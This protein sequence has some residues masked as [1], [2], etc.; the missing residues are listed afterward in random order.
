MHQ[1]IRV[2]LGAMFLLTFTSNLPAKSVVK[3][4]GPKFSLEQ[5]QQCETKL[6]AYGASFTILKKIDGPGQCGSPRPLN[7]KK[8]KGGIWI[9][10]DVVVRCEMALAL[11]R[12]TS[13][14]LIP[15]AQLHLNARP[16]KLN[17]STSYK[18]RRRN[19]NPQAR[20]SEHAFANGI[21]FMGISFK[22]I[23]PMKVQARNGSSSAMR[24][25]Q[26]AIRGG[27]CAHFTTVIGPMTN[28]AHADHLHLDLVQRHSGYR[29]CE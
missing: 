16:A 5:A 2:V 26:A 21:D 22:Q 7:L 25:F 18:C 8:L 9:D 19:N 11:A 28:A 29:V 23:S 20:L 27:A 14:V 12:W 3:D 17:I 4:P 13:D 10:G 1:F 15:S 6:S 24:A